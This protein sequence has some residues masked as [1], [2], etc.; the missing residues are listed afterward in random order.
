METQKQKVDRLSFD[1]K[2][3]TLRTVERTW[4]FFLF[5]HNPKNH[6]AFLIVHFW[7]QG[8]QYQLWQCLL[9]MRVK[10]VSAAAVVFHSQI[11]FWKVFSS[12]SKTPTVRWS[13]AG[14]V[15]ASGQS[16]PEGPRQV[17]D[18]DMTGGSVSR[19]SSRS[20]NLQESFNKS[21]CFTHICCWPIKALAPLSP[22]G[23]LST[24]DCSTYI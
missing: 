19:V 1:F 14:S 12:P 24:L 16:S 18:R 6:N 11:F 13:K 15:L 7:R 4:I 10:G 3:K 22:T 2:P 21:L 5:L 20:I 17:E 23:H 8:Q 9:F